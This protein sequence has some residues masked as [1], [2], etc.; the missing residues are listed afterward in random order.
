MKKQYVKPVVMKRENLQA[1]TADD[2]KVLSGLP[3]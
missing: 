2:G 3:R 1:I